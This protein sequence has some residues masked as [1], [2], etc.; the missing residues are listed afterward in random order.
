MSEAP[1]QIRKPEVARAIRRLAQKKGQAIT[2]AV[3]DVVNAELCRLEDASEAEAQRR[4]ARA[5]QIVARFQALPTLG[6]VPTDDDFY[7]EAGFPK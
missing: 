3:A 6:P 5:K 2:D 1:I 4:I 7:D